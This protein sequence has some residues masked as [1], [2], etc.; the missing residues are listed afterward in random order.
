[1][2]WSIIKIGAEFSKIQYTDFGE[3]DRNIW[4][5][6]IKQCLSRKDYVLKAEES[7]LNNMNCAL[8]LNNK[9]G[10]RQTRVRRLV[11]KQVACLGL[12]FQLFSRQSYLRRRHE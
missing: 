8:H 2:I 1:M 12:L 9:T 6:M 4:M 7:E 11:D 5:A 10:F 3:S